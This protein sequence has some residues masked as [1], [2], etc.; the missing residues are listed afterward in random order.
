MIYQGNLHNHETKGKG[1]TGK[2]MKGKNGKIKQTKGKFPL[3]FQTAQ[4]RI[5]N[6]DFGDT[7][8]QIQFY[9]PSFYNF[10]VSL[11]ISSLTSA[12]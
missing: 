1:K 10:P 6:Q 8:V 2:K 7:F 9:F 11:I 5:R 4:R 12:F 3:S